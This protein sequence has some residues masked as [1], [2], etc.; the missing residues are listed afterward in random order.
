MERSRPGEDE[1]QLVEGVFS[2]TAAWC[3]MVWIIAFILS[4]AMGLLTYTGGGIE[5]ISEEISFI[6]EQLPPYG[7]AEQ[8][9]NLGLRDINQPFRY[10]LPQMPLYFALASSSLGLF[11]VCLFTTLMLLELQGSRRSVDISWLI[12]KGVSVYMSRTLPCIYV[13]IFAGG[14]Y[15]YVASGFGTA[16]CFLAG[17]SLNMVSAK[18]GVSTCMASTSRLAHAMGEGLESSVTLGL[19]TGSIGGLLSTSL[20][21][22]GMALMWLVTLDTT[23]LSGFGSGASLVSFY[24]RVGGGI[25]SKGAEIGA[26]LVG[27]MSENKMEEERRVYELQQRMAEM[28]ALRLERRKKGLDEEEEDMMDQL[29]MMEE[30]MKDIASTMHPIDYLDAVGKTICDVSGTCAD[31]FESMVLNLSLSLIIGAKGS[32]VP[33]FFTALPLW[34]VAS[35]N[36]ACTFVAHRSHVKNRFSSRQLRWYMRLNLLFVILFVQFVQILVSYFEYSAGGITFENF[37]HFTVISIMGSPSRFRFFAVALGGFGSANSGE[38]S[39]AFQEGVVSRSSEQ[40]RAESVSGGWMSFENMDLL[41]MPFEVPRKAQAQAVKKVK[42]SESPHLPD[43]QLRPLAPL[44]RFG[45][46]HSW[47][48]RCL[49]CSLSKGALEIFEG[50]RVTHFPVASAMSAMDRPSLLALTLGLGLG[51]ALEMLRSR[52]K[53]PPKEGESVKEST[54]R[55]MT[56]LALQHGAVNLSQ[57]FPNEPPPEQMARAASAALLQGASLETVQIFAPRLEQLLA[58][59]PQAERDLLSQYS[60]PFGLPLLRQTLQQ[61]YARFYPGLPADAEENLTVVLGATEGF[62]CTLRT[63]CSPGDKVVFFEPFH[64]LYPSQCRLW[65]LEPRAVT[66]REAAAGWRF[67]VSELEAALKGAR[68]LLLNTPHNPTGKVFTQ[69]ELASIA[70][71]CVK[72]DVFCA[73]DEIYEHIVFDGAPHVPPA[74]ALQ[75]GMADRTFVVNAVSKTARATGWRIGWVV[76]PKRFTGALRGVHDQLVVQAPTPLQYGACAMLT[77]NDDFFASH[78]HEYLEKRDILLVALR[79]AGFR[80]SAVPKGAYYLFADYLAVPRLKGLSPTEAAMTMTKEV[81]V[82]CVPGDNFYLGASKSDIA[83]GGRYLRFAFVRSMDLLKEA[84]EL[85]QRL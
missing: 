3:M 77:M 80:V 41:E 85:L 69:E 58:E 59:V 72:H 56:R 30:E 70:R 43:E 11:M 34:I 79:R 47:A 61:Y 31:L 67:E 19:R 2:W 50:Q 33:H 57:G 44:N 52:R 49:R 75:E 36:L 71:L 51:V 4:V 84:A 54:I 21:L 83:L 16:V 14:W 39:S 27:E 17:A 48:D 73:T 25:F 74:M 45:D 13:F 65:Y 6:R 1:A 10:H 53:K 66:L 5:R 26:D 8:P 9:M 18:V 29:R 76:S 46:D 15:V 64:E 23:A 60:M 62:A 32:G 12:S 68:L 35:G 28:E 81:G 7:P 55:L 63:L 78:A 24:L 40:L 22:G 20:G 42:R 37:W 82:A 38:F